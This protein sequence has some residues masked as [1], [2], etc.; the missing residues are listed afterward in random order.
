MSY[1]PLSDQDRVD[2]CKMLGEYRRPEEII[3]AIKQ[4]GRSIQLT[5]INYYRQ[6]PEWRHL[7]EKFRR[8]Y[9]NGIMDVPI[10]Q[11]RVRLE[12]L[13]RLIYNLDN[14]PEKFELTGRE[15][16]DRIITVLE[17]SR[18]EMEP[19]K[20]DTFNINMAQ[21]NQL[22]DEEIKDRQE[23]IMDKIMKIQR[24]KEEM[25]ATNAEG[26]KDSVEHVETVRSQEG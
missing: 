12:K 26:I 2:V 11:K 22:T 4:K 7:I 19:S 8:D 6:K 14:H 16:F 24:A 18:L 10:S 23:V 5:S 15:I 25:N 17:K 1:K 13:D 3:D 20:G 21:F 9:L